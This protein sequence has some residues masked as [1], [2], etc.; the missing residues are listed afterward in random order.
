MLCAHVKG[1]G[2][3]LWGAGK[4]ALDRNRS[5]REYLGLQK[6]EHILGTLLFGYPAVKFKN[7]MMG[8]ML[9]I[10]WMGHPGNDEKPKGE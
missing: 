8:K 4:I 5:A 7:R 9:D 6:H 3:C 1:I 2:T 10:Q